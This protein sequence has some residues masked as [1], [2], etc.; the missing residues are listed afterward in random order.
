MDEYGN[1]GVAEVVFERRFKA[2]RERIWQALTDPAELAGWLAPA[3]IDLRVGGSVLLRFEEG[4]ERGT[5]TELR[6]LEVIAYTWNEGQ[7]DSTVRFELQNDGDGTRLRLQH[8]FD[9]EVDLSSYGG[10]WHHHLEQ[11]MAQVAGEPI[12]WDS[13]RFRELKSEYE[14]KAVQRR[15][16]ELAKNG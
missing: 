8:T 7:T 4:D 9:G 10:G 6:E 16:A 5:I 12:A 3:E 15:E 11:L 2:S 14:L 13:N 1:M